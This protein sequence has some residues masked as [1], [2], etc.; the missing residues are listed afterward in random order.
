MAEYENMKKTE[1]LEE[2]K[3]QGLIGVSKKNKADLIDA[4][5]HP[6]MHRQRKKTPRVYEGPLVVDLKREAK[7]RKIPR[8]Y[9]MNKPQLMQALGYGGARVMTGTSRMAG[10]NPSVAPGNSIVAM[11]EA[12]LRRYGRSVGVTNADSMPVDD[13][14]DE[15]EGRGKY[16]PG[17]SKNDYEY[18]KYKWIPEGLQSGQVWRA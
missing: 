5:M 7:E 8:W 2:A 15:L 6:E 16:G 1:L 3:R 13:L 18:F 4:L 14:F 17:V 10:Y 12:E 11:P 9:H